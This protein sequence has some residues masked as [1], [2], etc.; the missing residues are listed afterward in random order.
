MPAFAKTWE[1]VPN[2]QEPAGSDIDD[3]NNR[4]MFAMHQAM[5]DQL[6]TVN[7]AGAGITMSVPVT[8]LASSDSVTADASDN[9]G[10]ATDI[11]H[12]NAGSAH[13]W[14]NGRYTDF[15][16]VGDHLD[17]VIDCIPADASDDAMIYMAF[18][19][20]GWNADGTTT[21]RPTPVTPGDLLVVRDGITS[22]GTI[23]T[24]DC[25][26]GSDS[27]NGQAVLHYAIA[28]DGSAVKCVIC[29][30]G[31]VTAFWGFQ[32]DVSGPARA[33]ASDPY[34]VFYLCQ[35]GTVEILTEVLT[36]N[37]AWFH[38]HDAAGAQAA[39]YV[40]TYQYNNSTAS[41]PAANVS[42]YDSSRVPL[43]V[44]M[45]NTAPQGVLDAVPDLWWGYTGDVTGDPSPTT[46]TTNTAQIGDYLM[47]YPD[48][49]V[50]LIT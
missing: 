39:H 10:A 15:F 31:V 45:A 42:S 41:V 13:S 29:Q 43:P 49:V 14:M 32:H 7:Q 28:D 38:T 44:F 34:S 27:I 4:L 46:G 11:V 25:W 33:A 19:R 36:D 12:A 1:Y 26:A 3:R 24:S 8:V 18:S 37:E 9:W 21:N 30:S 16:G 2:L 50:M 20:D 23:V 17:Y 5:T 47:P 40:V 48:N 35:D 6:A 22:S